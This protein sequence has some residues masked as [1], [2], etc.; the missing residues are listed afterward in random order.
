MQIPD[1]LGL[2]GFATLAVVDDDGLRGYG[3]LEV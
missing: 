1:L 3:L 2:F